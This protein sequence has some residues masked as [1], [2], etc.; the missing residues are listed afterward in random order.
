MIST[1][2]ETLIEFR[3]IP[4]H[5]EKIGGKKVSLATCYR[6]VQ[7]GIAGV[8]LETICIGGTRFSII[9]AIDRFC[10]E[11]TKAKRTRKKAATTGAK[12]LKQRQIESEETIGRQKHA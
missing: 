10:Q 11:S 2:S 6:W 8:H 5:L 4:A 7:T 12:H 3:K 9:A 1:T